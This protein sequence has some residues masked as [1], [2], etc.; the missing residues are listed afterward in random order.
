MDI[1]R[2][3]E[4]HEIAPGIQGKL[5]LIRTNSPLDQLI[6]KQF[7]QHLHSPHYQQL[8]SQKRCY[9]LGI[10]E[11]KPISG[12]GKPSLRYRIGVPL[13]YFLEL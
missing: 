2:T 6:I 12:Y 3:I 4:E 9:D 11:E 8:P 7:I 10:V 13:E 5:L 1:V